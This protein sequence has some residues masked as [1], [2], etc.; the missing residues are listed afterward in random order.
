M[1]H[2]HGLTL[3]MLMLLASPLA[4]AQGDATLAASENLLDQ[5][6]RA[7]A[8][9]T[10]LNAG[11]RVELVEQKGGWAL[12]K[13]AGMQGW[14]RRIALRTQAN[15]A[16]PHAGPQYRSSVFQHAAPVLVA[17]IRKADETQARIQLLTATPLCDLPDDCESPLQQLNIGTALSLVARQDGWALVSGGEA[18][19]QGWIAE[20]AA[21]QTA[22]AS[23]PGAVVAL[24]NCPERAP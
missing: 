24:P 4:L 12:V 20:T 21:C 11:M 6:A 22:P 23:T 3:A 1:T 14:V 8:S 19:G 7:G 17:G 10:R 15:A 16:G 13:V 18:L 5:P 2:V 9:L